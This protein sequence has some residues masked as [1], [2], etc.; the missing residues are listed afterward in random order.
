M[1]AFDPWAYSLS[2]KR[3][4]RIQNTATPPA[5]WDCLKKQE[6]TEVALP[7]PG[8]CAAAVMKWTSLKWVRHLPAPWSVAWGSRCQTW[9]GVPRTRPDAQAPSLQNP[10]PLGSESRPPSSSST[11]KKS[12]WLVLLNLSHNL[13]LTALQWL[14]VQPSRASY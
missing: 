14:L 11:S 4:Y 5:V 13:P 6:Q 7:L 12:T 3:V 2:Q 10:Y 1:W 8:C 9:E